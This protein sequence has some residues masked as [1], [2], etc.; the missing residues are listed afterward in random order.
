M[1]FLGGVSSW[2]EILFLKL[3]EVEL[4]EVDEHDLGVSGGIRCIWRNWLLSNS[5]VELCF[6]LIF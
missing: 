2:D 1:N 6:M 5:L 3:D 4:G